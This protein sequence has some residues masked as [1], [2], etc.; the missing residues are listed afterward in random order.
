MWVTNDVF[1]NPPQDTILAETGPLNPGH[2]SV[3][4]VLWS[5]P[6]G[7]LVDFLV[8]D[9]ANV[10]DVMVQLFTAAPAVAPLVLPVS[11]ALNQRVI[12][13]MADN[14]TGQIQASLFW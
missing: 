9:A 6:A 3:T 11:V 8:R 10:D 1:A 4:L 12:V 5:T 14:F 2:L 13:R 7:G